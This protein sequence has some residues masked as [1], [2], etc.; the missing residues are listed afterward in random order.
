MI[1]S[2]KSIDNTSRTN[3]R[4]EIILAGP[5]RSLPFLEAALDW[6]NLGAVLTA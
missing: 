4:K 6:P 1:P 3:Q 5:M 2:N